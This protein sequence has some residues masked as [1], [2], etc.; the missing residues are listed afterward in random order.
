[1]YIYMYTVRELT[2]ITEAL[3][4]DEKPFPVIFPEFLDWISTTTKEVSEASNAPHTPGTHTFTCTQ[5]FTTIIAA[6]VLFSVLV[7]HNGYQYDFPIL[8]AEIER[9]DKAELTN[10]LITHN[11]RFAD[12]LHYLKQVNTSRT[13]YFALNTTLST[14][15]HLIKTVQKKLAPVPFGCDGHALYIS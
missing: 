6:T 15:V 4:R 1:M 7:A 3:L 5:Y 11:I 2:G 13:V 8:L 12:T 10:W 14:S 9:S